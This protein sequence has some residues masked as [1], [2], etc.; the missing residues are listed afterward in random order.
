MTAF[1]RPIA[2]S[3]VV[4]ALGLFWLSS[5]SPALDET[6]TTSTG[7]GIDLAGQDRSV[8]P[9]DDFFAHANGSWLKA[10]EIPPIALPTGRVRCC[11]S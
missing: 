9:G 6:P 4:V 1:A 11:S 7:V 3:T 8:A 2:R 5:A 10:T